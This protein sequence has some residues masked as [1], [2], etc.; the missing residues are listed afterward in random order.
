MKCPYCN[1][2]LKNGEIVSSR[3]MHWHPAEATESVEAMALTKVGV[4]GFLKAAKEGF[5]LEAHYCEACKKLIVP[6]E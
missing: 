5:S 2:E 1:A 3:G 4:K 6:L